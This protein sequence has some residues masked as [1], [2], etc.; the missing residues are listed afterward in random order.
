MCGKRRESKKERKKR[1]R[2]EEGRKLVFLRSN[3]SRGAFRVA[4]IKAEVTPTPYPPCP[5]GASRRRRWS[6]YQK[7]TT[8]PKRL[9]GQGTSRNAKKLKFLYTSAY[10]RSIPG[11]LPPSP[12]VPMS[13]LLSILVSGRIK[14]TLRSGKKDTLFETS[15]KEKLIK[16][17]WIMLRS[18]KSNEITQKREDCRDS[19][20]IENDNWFTID[21]PFLLYSVQS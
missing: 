3:T 10:T 21:L 4:I 19:A 18:A 12:G 20:F 11:V 15:V 2:E 13:S 5:L 6:S 7:Q 14:S 9:K 1:E 16:T 8:E 17:L